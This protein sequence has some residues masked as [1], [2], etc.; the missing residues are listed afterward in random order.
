MKKPSVDINDFAATAPFRG[1]TCLTC[2]NYKKPLHDQIAKGLAIIK[3]GTTNLSFAGLWEF[4]CAEYGY[5][6]KCGALRKHTIDCIG[7]KGRGARS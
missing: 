2:K 6:L 1:N 7:I 3:K 4:L 5:K